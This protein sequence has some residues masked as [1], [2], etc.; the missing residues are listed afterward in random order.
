MSLG[1]PVGEKILELC[2]YKEKNYITEV[3]R[4]SMLN[5]FIIIY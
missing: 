3:K 1:F 4:V 5:L 2:S